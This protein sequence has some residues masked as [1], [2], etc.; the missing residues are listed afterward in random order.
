[1]SPDPAGALARVA[2]NVAI[3]TTVAD[4]HP[5]GVTANVWG[6]GTDPP[7]VLVTLRRTA[8]TLGAVRAAGRFGAC[9]LGAH[10]EE[11]AWRFARPEADPGQRFAGVAHHRVADMPVLDVTHAWFVCE[12]EGAAPFGSYEIVTGRVVDAGTGSADEPLIFHTGR[13]VHLAPRMERS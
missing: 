4:G 11:V 10:Q 13:F 1:M 5:H 3:V 2:T 6:E 8:S 12:V 7:F 9:L